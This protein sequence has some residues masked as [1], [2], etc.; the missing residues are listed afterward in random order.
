[1]FPCA[2]FDSARASISELRDSTACGADYLCAPAER[3]T[4]IVLTIVWL[5]T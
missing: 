4:S 3:F 5:G 1:M 2:F